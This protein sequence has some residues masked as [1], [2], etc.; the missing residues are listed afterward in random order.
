MKLYKDQ[1]KNLV[2]QH[3]SQIDTKFTNFL[4][5]SQ[6]LGDPGEVVMS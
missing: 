4:D 5:S 6:C 3:Y 1:H 2:A